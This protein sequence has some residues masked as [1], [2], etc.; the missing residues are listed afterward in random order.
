MNRSLALAALSLDLVVGNVAIAQDVKPFGIRV[1]DGR[2]GRGVPL[3]ELRTTNDIPYTTDSGGWVAF[4]EPGL[5]GKDVFFSVSSPGY[6]YPKDGFGYRGVR[7]TTT[8]GGTATVRG[9]PDQPGRAALS[10]HGAGNLPGL[11]P[12]RE[13]P[14]QSRTRT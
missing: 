8:A 13:T 12:A 11:R 3:V 7:F 9:D 14:A 10:R 1:V 6:E 2:T 4:D 5:L